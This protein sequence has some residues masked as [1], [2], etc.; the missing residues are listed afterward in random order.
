LAE[1]YCFKNNEKLSQALGEGISVGLLLSA[2][3]GPVFFALIQASL[4]NGFRYAAVLASGILLSDL[5]YV[6][7]TFFGIKI[8]TGFES[9][10]T[11]LG[12]GGGL[13]L[14][15]F[16]ISS[17]VKKQASR[18]NSGGINLPRIK[19]RSAFAKGFS[20]NGINPFVLLF[21]ISIASVLQVKNDF[22]ESDYFVYYL[23]VLLTVFCI[24]LVKAFIAKQLA[25]LVTDRVL[26]WLNKSVGVLMIGYGIRMIWQTVI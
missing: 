26:F 18:P 14:I 9:F 8:I 16:G 7:I 13:I 1:V 2:L 5:I 20:I 17:I 11:I 22:T 12:F 19:K 15:G 21:W 25:P 6:L 24:D 10:E 4:T 3:I 23:G